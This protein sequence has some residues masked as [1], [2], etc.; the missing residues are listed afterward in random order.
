MLLYIGI[1]KDITRKIEDELGLSGYNIGESAKDK[2]VR[3]II[4]NPSEFESEKFWHERKFVL[5][6]NLSNDEIKKVLSTF[7]SAH[8]KDVIFATTTKTSLEWKLS[9]LLSE[10]I[11]EDEYF[12]SKDREK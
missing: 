11:K 7:K 8:V 3:E 10:L 2:L 12:K 4:E 6:H 9:D 5:M 1:N